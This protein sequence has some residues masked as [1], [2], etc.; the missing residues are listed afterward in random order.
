LNG[1]GLKV[2]DFDGVTNY[3]NHSRFSHGG[4]NLMAVKHK[5]ATNAI[6]KIVF[7]R[8][9]MSCNYCIRG[10]DLARC[11]FAAIWRKIT[12]RKISGSRG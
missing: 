2:M 11:P 3:P 8:A 4:L 6:K 5:P 10:R 9:G 1:F 7:Q 12:A